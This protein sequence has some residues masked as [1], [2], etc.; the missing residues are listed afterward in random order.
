MDNKEIDIIIPVSLEADGATV[1]NTVASI[2]EQHRLFGFAKFALAMPSKGWRSIS[3]PPEEYFIEKAN[4]FLEVKK[5]LPADISCGW[6]HTL[7]LKSGPTPGLTRVVREDGTEA[8]FS[9]CPLDPEYRRRFAHD[10][11]TVL[12]ICKPAFLLTE[13]DFGMNCHGGPGCYCKYHLEEFAKREGR[14]YSRE[15]LHELFSSHQVESRELLRRF[16]ALQ[17]DSLVVFAKAIRA[18]ADEVM[19]ELPI[20]YDQPGCSARDGDCVEAVARALAGEKTTPWVRFCGADYCAEYISRIPARLFTCL[21]YRQHIH[22]K[23]GFYHES[24][25]YPHTRFY[26]SASAMRV[27]MSVAYSFGY[28]GSIFQT[29]QLLDDPN[30]EKAYGQMFANERRRFNSLRGKVQG[31]RVRGAQLLHDPF[32]SANFP[33][34]GPAWLWALVSMGIPYTTEDAETAFISGNQL[35]FADDKTILKYLSKGLFLDGLAAKVLCER[36]Y[37]EYLGVNVQK[38]LVEDYGKYDLEAREV[39]RPGFASN[40][41]GRRMHRGDDYSPYGNGDLYR[42]EV[43]NPACE[44]ITEIVT[45]KNETMA[46]GM[47]RFQNKLGGKVVVYATAMDSN[48][49]SS[50]YNYRR[51]KLLQEL[52]CWCSDYL[53][54]VKNEP[55]VCL[56]VNEAPEESDYVGVLTCINLCPDA[57]E[58]LELHLPMAWRRN[59]VFKIMDK[60]GGWRNA[61]VEKTDDGIVL[62]CPLVYTEPVYLLAEK[63]LTC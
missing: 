51:Q 45:C 34:N 23:F 58:K 56:V 60:D 30:E 25:S 9:T 32:E 33:K 44:W 10:V 13:D 4:M 42:I 27:F 47:T 59:V 22:G 8:P 53:P 18:A 46:P 62:I 6:W 28:D 43:T 20:G 35:L 19:P 63:D 3:Y 61:P 39:I 21:Y 17:K 41:K 7:V 29:Q 50:L 24:D 57:L 14:Y 48:L 37:G 15:E 16:Q 12:K 5:Q 54:F 2:L 52:L 49:S 36:G 40:S 31:C 1:E 55:R 11:A 38:L 26:V